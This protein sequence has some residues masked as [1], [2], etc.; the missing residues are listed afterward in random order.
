[1]HSHVPSPPFFFYYFFLI[2]APRCLSLHF[3]Y[4]FK[5]MCG[6]ATVSELPLNTHVSQFATVSFTAAPNS[7]LSSLQT[8]HVGLIVAVCVVS[9]RSMTTAVQRSRKEPMCFQQLNI[10]QTFLTLLRIDAIEA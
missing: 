3:Y 8:S 2:A 6:V 9:T 7:A 4:V 1:M 10:T 5:Q